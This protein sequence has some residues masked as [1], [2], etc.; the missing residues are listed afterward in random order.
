[1]QLWVYYKMRT[2]LCP[3]RRFMVGAS[4]SCA[5]TE[6]CTLW[7]LIATTWEARWEKETLRSLQMGTSA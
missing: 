5:T 3:C 1:M 6:R 7:M 4:P 2:P